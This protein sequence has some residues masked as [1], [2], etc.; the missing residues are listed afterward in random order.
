VVSLADNNG[1]VTI[2]YDFDPFGNQLSLVTATDKNPY[3]Y[4]GEYYDFENGDT[5]LRARYYD[6][7]I[8]RFIS[9]D[10]ALDGDNWYAYAG[11]DPINHI[12]PS[13][14]FIETL[15]DIA[16][17]GKSAWD[18]ITKPSWGNM[19]YLAW[20]LE[21]TLLP[22]VPG[23]YVK[24]GTQA[25]MKVADKA[26]DFKHS[27]KCMSLGTYNKLHKIYKGKRILKLII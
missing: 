9:E 4:S 18:F 6:P 5:Y 20:D 3:R 17:V 22:I 21:A 12:D 7:R 2:N 13:G 1:T 14:K 26:S 27:K 11:N 10:P 16:S 24:K 23:S 25:A 8:G 19:G 15:I